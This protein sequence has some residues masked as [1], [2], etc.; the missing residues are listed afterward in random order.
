MPDLPLLLDVVIVWLLLSG[1]F[2]LL[3][4]TAGA[5][6]R[7]RGRFSG[8][9]RTGDDRRERAGDRR[10]GLPDTREVCTERRNGLGDRR[11][12]LADRRG[13]PASV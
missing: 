4:L 3:L 9:R 13:S 2:A 5:R 7:G 8:D 12:R 10:V 6:L 1:L 11:Q